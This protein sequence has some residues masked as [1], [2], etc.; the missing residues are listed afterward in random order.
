MVERRIVLRYDGAGKLEEE[1]EWDSL[2]G[3]RDDLRRVFRYDS[4]G[5]VVEQEQT[6]HHYFMGTHRRSFEYNDRGDV[7]EERH[8]R[9]SEIPEPRD[10]RWVV[11]Y[12]YQ[13]DARGNWVERVAET[14]VDEGSS[15]GSIVERR[16]LDYY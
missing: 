16:R 10:Q 15:T 5:R 11:R 3:I 14:I 12:R 6:L 1:G 13:Y 7:S 8:H 2:G 9:A 4:A